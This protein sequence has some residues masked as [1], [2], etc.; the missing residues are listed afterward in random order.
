MHFETN[1]FVLNIQ[2]L[3]TSVNNELLNAFKLSL[4]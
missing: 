4:I 1:E 2:H 3:N